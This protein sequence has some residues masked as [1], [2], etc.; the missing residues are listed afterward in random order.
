MSMR[1][2]KKLY[3]TTPLR[4]GAT[5]S[6][7]GEEETPSTYEAKRPMK[8]ESD[9]FKIHRKNILFSNKESSSNKIYYDKFINYY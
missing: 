7:L 5:N 8:L 6:R 2:N 1:K 4:S 3:I 9:E